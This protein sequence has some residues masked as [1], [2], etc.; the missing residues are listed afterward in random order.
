[1]PI[2]RRS[3][4]VWFAGAAIA[5]AARAATAVRKRV[6]YAGPT[7]ATPAVYSSAV[8]WGNVL[9]LAGKG[10]GTSPDPADIRSCTD[11]V[12]TEFD[13]ELRNAGSSM[14][15]VLKVTVYLQQPEHVSAMNEMFA[16]HFPH[17]PP[18]RTTIITRTP[19][20]TLV[21]MDMIAG[22]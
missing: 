21:E 18:A 4:A 7:P 10:S 6:F 2:T 16:R 5:P 13:K 12:L 17:D 15:K 9:F 8:A 22:I 20:P 3:L 1:M 14:E 19:H 11:Y